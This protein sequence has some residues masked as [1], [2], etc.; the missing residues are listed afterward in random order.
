MKP[1]GEKIMKSLLRGLGLLFVTV[2]AISF[3]CA[4]S[5]PRDRVRPTQEVWDHHIEAWTSRDLEAIA[6]DYDTHSLLIV[7]GAV[8]QGPAEIKE[9]F[10]R[11]FQIFD[12]GSNEI[13]TP[14][15]QDRIVFLTWHFTPAGSE[16]F[17]GTDTFVIEDGV[18]RIQTIASRLYEN[19][20]IEK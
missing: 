8:F 11:L 15:L 6:S 17:D 10:R 9:V 3:A 16:T 2:S 13:D 7:N 20:P 18:I 5:D 12:G 4:Q 14:I 19:F 1:M